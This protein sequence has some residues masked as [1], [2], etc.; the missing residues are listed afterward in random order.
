MPHDNDATPT[1]VVSRTARKAG[2][3]N[4]SAPGASGRG[5][6]TTLELGVAYPTRDRSVRTRARSRIPSLRTVVRPRCCDVA[7]NGALS[8]KESG[9]RRARGRG[10]ARIPRRP[11]NPRIEPE[12]YLT[13]SPTGERAN[14]AGA[15]SPAAAILRDSLADCRSGPGEGPTDYAGPSEGDLRAKFGS[16]P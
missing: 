9:G 14:A 5:R 6:R 12:G 1:N 16:P 7:S 4:G 8:P 2:P 15:A 3:Q 13:Y 10:V 11:P